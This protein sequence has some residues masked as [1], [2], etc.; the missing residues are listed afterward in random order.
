MGSVG[1]YTLHLYCDGEHTREGSYE[2][3]LLANSVSPMEFTGPTGRA[4]WRRARLIGWTGKGK[5]AYCPNCSSKRSTEV[6]R[7]RGADSVPEQ[8]EQ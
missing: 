4:C 3:Y 1:C 8:N 7:G 2:D 5:K 6:S